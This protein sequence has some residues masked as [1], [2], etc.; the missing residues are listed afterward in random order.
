MPEIIRDVDQGSEE[1]F[2]YRLGSVGG[3]SIDAV[4]AKG[5][6]KTRKSLM[7][8]LAGEIL[9]GIKTDSY[10][11]Q[12]M[13]RGQ[14]YEDEARKYYEFISGNTVEQVALIKSDIFGVHVSP[15][16]LV[17][18]DGGVEIKVRLPH[19][20]VELLDTEKI[21]T[22]YMRQCQ[23]FLWVT[24]RG[25]ID[26]INYCPEITA[27]PMWKKRITPDPKIIDQIEIELPIFLKELSEMVRRVG[28]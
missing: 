8:K 17:G 9:S 1:W 11:N 23:H 4:L 15:D 24:G 16:G 12:Y 10:T 22:G 3:C 6:G 28:A 5:K 25:W 7:Y 14:E 27:N 19:V 13:Q 2:K 18:S 20:Y 21:E 26:F